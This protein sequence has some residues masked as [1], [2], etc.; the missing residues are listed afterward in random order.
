MFPFLDIYVNQAVKMP[1]E[2]NAIGQSELGSGISKL[3]E[4]LAVPF[5]ACGFQIRTQIARSTLAPR[6]FEGI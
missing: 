4:Q 3:E 2:R 5:Q 6:G 1:I